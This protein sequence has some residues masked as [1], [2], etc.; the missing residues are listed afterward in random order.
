M[1]S[2]GRIEGSANDKWKTEQMR[3]RRLAKKKTYTHPKLPG[4]YM[5]C[6]KV[7]KCLTL[8]ESENVIRS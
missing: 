8:F 5:S 4:P 6:T 7:R 3:L 2:G 1:F